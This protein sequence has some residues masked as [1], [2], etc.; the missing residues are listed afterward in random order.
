MAQALNFRVMNQGRDSGYEGTSCAA[1]TFNAIIAL[2]NS[3]RIDSG[4]PTLGFLNPWL[5]GAG[6][7]GL[8]DVTRGWSEGCNGYLNFFDG[9]NGSPVL[10][11]A[12]WNASVGWMR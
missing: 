11:G 2:L 6:R 3:V 5:Y 12:G 8:N 10:L 1:P 7:W 9:M 4:L